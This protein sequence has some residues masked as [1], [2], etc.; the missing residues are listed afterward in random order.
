M[1]TVSRRAFVTASSVG[2]AA[3]AAVPR[4]ASAVV[5]WMDGGLPE[6]FP[7]QDPQAVRLVVLKSHVDYEAVREMVT[8]RPAL[9]KA[10]W[11]WGF[12]DWESA[13]GAASHMGRRDIAE[14]LLEHGAR[15]NLF[16]FAMLGQVDVIRAMCTANPGLQRLHGPHGITLLQH[17]V[18]GGEDAAAVVEYLQE[19]GDADLGQTNLPLDESTIEACTGDYEPDGVPGV[20]FRIEYHDRMK[21]LRFGRDDRQPRSLLRE[22]GY[23]FNPGGAPSVRVTFDV[24]HGRATGLTVRDGDLVINATKRD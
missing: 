10:A 3:A 18:N 19:L 22:T 12:G 11:D 14:V 24:Q 17:A 16:T 1:S 7:T 2:V 20:R 13:L 4:P 6:G 8:R 5:S 9:A 23:T 21:L 15:P